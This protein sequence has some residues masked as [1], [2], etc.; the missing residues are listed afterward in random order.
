MYHQKNSVLFSLIRDLLF[1]NQKM[2]SKVFCFVAT[3]KRRVLLKEFMEGPQYNS[4]RDN[5]YYASSFLVNKLKHDKHFA[6]AIEYQCQKNDT[7][8]HRHFHYLYYRL[9]EW[10]P[11]KFGWLAPL[12]A[13]TTKPRFSCTSTPP[14]WK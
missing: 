3:G 9:H 8:R 13:I 10:W 2:N 5:Y 12:L 7:Y 1:K 11:V 14:C 4:L 6:T